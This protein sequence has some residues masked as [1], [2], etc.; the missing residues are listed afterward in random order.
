MLY[1]G[2]PNFYFIFTY[3]YSPWSFFLC[4]HLLLG[5]CVIYFFGFYV[6]IW[7]NSIHKNI[8]L[9]PKNHANTLVRFACV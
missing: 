5:Q 7:D 6:F 4:Y 3:F 1:N 8:A 9:A 2:E